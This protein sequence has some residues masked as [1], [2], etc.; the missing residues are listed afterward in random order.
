M[1]SVKDGTFEA[2]PFTTQ[3]T[4]THIYTPT[5]INTH[6]QTHRKPYMLYSINTF[7]IKK[8]TQNVDHQQK[9]F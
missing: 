6:T 4:H 3:L 1:N 9:I 5:H 2:Q 7:M 8:P